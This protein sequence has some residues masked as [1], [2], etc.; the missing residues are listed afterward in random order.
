MKPLSEEVKCRRQKMIGQILKQDQNNDCNM[1]MT[2]GQEGKKRRERPETTWR[3]MV[4]KEREE[5][6]WKPWNEVWI[7]A[8]DQERWKHSVKALCPMRRQADM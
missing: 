1:A 7:V 8:A 6:G 4:G 5:A 2:R 3:H